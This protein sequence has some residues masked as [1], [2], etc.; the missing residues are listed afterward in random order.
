MALAS[1]AR[2]RWEP[3]VSARAHQLYFVFLVIAVATVLA[4]KNLHR[5]NTGRAMMAVR[6][7]DLAAAVLGVDPVRTKIIAFG[8]SSFFGG[9]AGAM[10]GMQLQYVTPDQFDLAMSV[11]YIAMI[12]LGGIGTVQGAVTG[13]IAIVAL[14]PLAEL[15]VTKI[16]FLKVL[17]GS[18]QLPTALLFALIVIAFLIFEPLGLYGI[19]LR[20]KRFFITWP[21]SY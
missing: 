2:W 13:A 19:W 7:H 18:D 21:S 6:D 4:A 20:I 1:I 8:I 15:V 9:V 14:K 17:G 12:V 5:S 3:S 10:Y 11:G 16:E